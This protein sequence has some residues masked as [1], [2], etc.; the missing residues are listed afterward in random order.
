[1]A[2]FYL[3]SLQ[4]TF[5]THIF[6]SQSVS[7]VWRRSVRMSLWGRYMWK[8]QSF[9]QKS[10]GRYGSHLYLSIFWDAK[11]PHATRY[12][13]LPRTN[14]RFPTVQTPK[15]LHTGQPAKQQPWRI[16]ITWYSGLEIFSWR[17]CLR[18]RLCLSVQI[19]QH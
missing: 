9:L 18:A 19:F 13:H 4:C 14:F 2:Q 8:L 12:S 15:P 3:F 10:S 7:G 16:L 1:M 5:E 17:W 11:Y 6:N